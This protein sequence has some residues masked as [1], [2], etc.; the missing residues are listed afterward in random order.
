MIIRPRCYFGWPHTMADGA[1]SSL[2]VALHSNGRATGLVDHADCHAYWQRVRR[3]H[4]V[5]NGWGGD[6]VV[7]GACPHREA[8]T[9]RGPG[10]YR[11]G[12]A[13]AAGNRDYYSVTPMVGGAPT[14]RQVEVVT[15]PGVADQPGASERC[16]RTEAS[17]TQRGPG[18]LRGCWN[19]GR[20]MSI[21]RPRASAPRA[22]GPGA[23][24]TCCSRSPVATRP[25]RCAAGRSVR[26]TQDGIRPP[27][28]RDGSN[29]A[30]LAVV[31]R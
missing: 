4:T 15:E 26:K 12:Q 11:A 27:C 30:K 3:F 23:S 19:M 14:A 16:G 22:D 31:H 20:S 18:L 10:R 1:S 2:G 6:G 29:V 28:Q 17:S 8:F 7:F 9:G 24:A 5:D 25:S 21:P 13:T